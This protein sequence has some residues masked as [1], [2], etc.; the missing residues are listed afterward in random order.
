VLARKL[1][2]NAL[3][4]QGRPGLAT[5]GAAAAFAVTL[6]LDIAL[7]P[8]HGGLGAAI[9]STAAY[10]TGGIACGLIFARF[11]RFPARRLLP[12]PLDLSTIASVTIEPAFRRRGEARAP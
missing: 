11:F 2:G 12:R 5:A 3:R 9:A 10:S 6:G 1:L 4:A 8:A 7:I